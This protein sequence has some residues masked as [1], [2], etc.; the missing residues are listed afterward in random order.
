MS[1]KHLSDILVDGK[2]GVG[3]DSP[4]A[5][6]EIA[7]SSDNSSGLRFKTVGTKPALSGHSRQRSFLYI[8]S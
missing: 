1:V 7:D 4:T 2:I 6:I 5:Q 3:T 8:K